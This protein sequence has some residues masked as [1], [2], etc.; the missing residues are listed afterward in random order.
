M[1]ENNN[2][3]K[4]IKGVRI[5]TLYITDDDYNRFDQDIV[6]IREIIITM[7]QVDPEL[8]PSCMNQHFKLKEH[9]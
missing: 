4:T 5:I 9:T 6:F 7:V 8:F 2:T 1:T 3:E